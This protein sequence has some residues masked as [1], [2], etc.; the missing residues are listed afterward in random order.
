MWNT[1]EEKQ[2]WRCCWHGLDNSAGAPC[3]RG[4]MLRF[5]W[6]RCWSIGNKTDNISSLIYS[7][8]CNLIFAVLLL[9]ST[10]SQC[11]QLRECLLPQNG[12]SSCTSWLQVE[13]VPRKRRS[14]QPWLPD[15]LLR[16]N[17][18]LQGMLDAV[19][20]LHLTS[21]FSQCLSSLQFFFF[22]KKLKPNLSICRLQGDLFPGLSLHT[23]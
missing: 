16:G 9:L 2:Y 1:S 4:F 23:L 3:H 12:R 21:C 5:C 20:V 8:I 13:Y 18:L 7:D 22:L 17:H 10:A 6:Y 14:K 11:K 19:K 15:A